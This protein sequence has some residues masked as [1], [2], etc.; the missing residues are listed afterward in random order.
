MGKLRLNGLT[1]LPVFIEFL[2]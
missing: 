1:E 2:I